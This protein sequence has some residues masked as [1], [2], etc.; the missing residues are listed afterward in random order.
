VSDVEAVVVDLGQ[1]VLV[2]DPLPAVAAGVGEDEARRFLAARD[3][4]FDAWN[5]QQDAGRTWDEAEALVA[6]QHPHW[7]EHARA[8]RAHFDRSLLGEVPGTREVLQDLRDGGVPLFALTNWSAELFPHARERF[9]VLGLFEDVVVSGEERLA[10]PDP[11]VF[12]VL[13][14]RVGR[15][16]AR[17]VFVDDKTENV[18]AARAAGMDALLFTDAQAMR[19]EL[20][21]RGLPV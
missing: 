10:K 16:L 5:W 11:Q 13:Q 7:A 4:D 12:D 15:P 6:E 14:R 19:A 9:D 2:W 21:E 3:F 8:Y 20:R 17:C 1:V 18:A